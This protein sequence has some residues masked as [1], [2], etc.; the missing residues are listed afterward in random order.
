MCFVPS[1]ISK[2]LDKH[3]ILS[4][5]QH[6]FLAKSSCETQMVQTIEDISKSLDEKQHIDMAN[7]DFSKVFD[8]ESH[9]KLLFKLDHYGART[10]TF[11]WIRS[12]TLTVHSELY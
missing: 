4:D 5:N 2:H 10:N 3:N 9:S 1:N 7:L 12:W 11:N 6:G 8:A